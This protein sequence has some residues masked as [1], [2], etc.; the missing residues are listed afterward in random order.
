M[1]TV[2]ELRQRTDLQVDP[3]LAHLRALGGRRA[4][5]GRHGTLTYAE[6]AERVARV[7]E[8]YAGARRLVLLTPR[9]D[10]ASVVE[11]L[12]AHAA[13]QVVLLA[14][15]E[16]VDALRTSYDPDVLAGP[17]GR[18]F[19]RGD[20]AESAHD[21]HPSLSL[22][23]STSGS[24][25]SPKLVR[26][27]RTNLVANAR[28]IAQ[29][30]GIRPD[31]VAATTLPMHYCYGLSV[32]H[33]H[34]LTGAALCLTDDSVVTECFWEDVAAHGVTSLAGVPHTFELLGRS[35][36]ARR[37]VP[38][39]RYLTQAGGRMGPERVREYAEL[40]QRK[41]FDLFVMYGQT[42]ATARMAVLDPSLTTS[43]A[44]AV[45][46][47]VPGGSFSLAPVDHPEPGVGEL[48]YHGP[49]VMLGYAESPADLALGRTTTE[50]RTGDLARQR[51]DGLWEVVGR[52]KRIAK[53][54]GLR[55]D[56]DRVERGLAERGVIGA[57][58]DGGERLVVAVCSGARP[59]DEQLVTR[60]TA[61]VS[62][63]PAVGV[64]VLA[65]PDLPR[66]SNGKTDYASLV[67]P[68]GRPSAARDGRTSV[69]RQQAAKTPEVA[70]QAV[71]VVALYARLLD[72]PDARPT[73]SFVDLGGDSLSYVEVSIRLERLLGHL[74]PG[75]PTLPAAGL[76]EV[77][78]PTRRRGTLVESNVLIR[79]VAIV[80]IV[81]THANLFALLG[82][83]HL[84]L[85]VCGFN[86]GRFQVT[87]Q[88]RTARVWAVARSAVRVAVPSV[89][90]IGTVAAFSDAIGWRQVVLATSFTEWTWSE[91][92]WSYWFI[93]A[94]VQGLV[95]LAALLAIPA[96]DRLSRRRP[97]A[98]PVG[99]LVASLPL[100]YDVFGI[101][102]DH[103][104]R[105]H[106]ILWLLLLG[107][108]T[109]K[110][111]TTGQRVLLSVLA[112]GLTPGFFA[113]VWRPAYFVLGLLVLIWL[114]HVRVPR[115]AARLTGVLAGASLW[116]YLLHWQVYPH[117]E[118]S[119]PLVATLLSLVAGVAAWWLADRLTG[120][121]SG[122][123][124]AAATGYRPSG[125]VDPAPVL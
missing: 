122:R 103:L 6:L 21:L 37:D 44:G 75:W 10:V 28:S 104:H 18:T 92:R 113:G 5:V 119:L 42:E 46:R 97:F 39:L 101:P 24:T 31:D 66:L 59:V 64:R 112:V 95:V 114:P 85:A 121:V 1:T 30:L 56:L 68:G 57:V 11:Y 41:G 74:P 47:P 106:G 61:E 80:T 58:A 54:F 82:G 73:D 125:T 102:G 89:A 50:L 4:L 84:L 55:V 117:L 116:I 60:V 90:L 14:G 79:A 29:S 124:R 62:G 83:A 38:T 65:L 72:R 63:L 96:V 78:T 110:A 118:H 109:A 98:L 2:P 40:G 108:A 26:L 88:P 67:P 76:A 100:R 105:T 71:D 15:E 99:L 45:G 35:G 25:G 36:F 23:L 87:D 120:R 70:V 115:V 93:E 22:L 34:L 16:A 86:L 53:V 13:G 33:S 27:S 12:G 69:P 77:P 17:D 32:V 9:N 52:T 81:G 3:V 43:A 8:Q 7:A 91:P 107:W 20:R 111:R 123:V 94:L 49:N 19:L 48:V 51:D